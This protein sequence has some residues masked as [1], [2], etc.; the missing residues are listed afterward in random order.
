[1]GL[2]P[3]AGTPA[4]RGGCAGGAGSPAGGER[5]GAGGTGGGGRE[6]HP[7]VAARL[8]AALA[9]ISGAREALGEGPVLAGVSAGRIQSGA[10]ACAQTSSA[11][12]L[13]DARA[14]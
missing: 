3:L 12:T 8:D 2:G 7:G 9:Q 13:Q 6:L 11:Q 14:S 10:P 4:A 5:G 1:L